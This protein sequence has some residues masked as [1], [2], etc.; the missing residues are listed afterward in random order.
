MPAKTGCRGPE[1]VRMNFNQP[2]ELRRQGFRISLY[3]F[4]TELVEF[5]TI[6]VVI[7]VIKN[8]ITKT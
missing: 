1:G 5:V 3:T 6:N 7:F 8:K 2:A 4:S